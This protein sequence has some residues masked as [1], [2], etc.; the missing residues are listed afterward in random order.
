MS[1]L[2]KCSRCR[3]RF[4]AR[5]ERNEIP[6]SSLNRCRKRDG[7]SPASVAQ[8]A[9]VTGSPQNLADLHD[10]ARH[11]RIEHPLRQGFAEA[12]EIEFGAGEIVATLAAR[13]ICDRRRECGR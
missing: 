12:Q 4:Q 11:A 5:N 9:A 6:V 2:A 7:D 8:L 1:W 10:R 3:A 13:A